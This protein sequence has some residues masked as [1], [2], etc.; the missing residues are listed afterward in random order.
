[1][2]Q[3]K[4][5]MHTHTKPCS[6]CGLMS[7]RELCKGLYDNG[8]KGAVLTNHFMHGNT[9]VDRSLPWN[10]FVGAFEKDYHECL[11]AAK[12]FDLDILFGIEE[13]VVPGLE[14]LCYGLT[15]E[16]L[17]DNPELGTWG[18][19]KR[20]KILHDNGVVV[21]QAHPY[22]EASYIPNPGPL[23]LDLVDGI[24]IYNFGNSSTEMNKKAMELAKSNPHLIT[25][26]G[27]DA[28]WVE[29][30]PYGGIVTKKRIRTAKELA[31]TLKNKEFETIIS[32]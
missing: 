7:P 13:V 12:E 29:C 8:Y 19:E 28:H 30:I 16:I 18:L 25:T 6:R 17:Y 26:S 14:V 3:Y 4:Y 10:E 20:I 1:M 32:Y 2:E 21:I 31:D 23:P 9:G 24:E 5:Q 22:R 11:E 27:A 15:P